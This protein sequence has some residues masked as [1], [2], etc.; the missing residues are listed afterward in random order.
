MKSGDSLS[1]SGL[2]CNVIHFIS[3]LHLF[4]CV[5]VNNVSGSVS[6]SRSKSLIGSPIHWLIWTS[7]CAYYQVIVFPVLIKGVFCLKCNYHGI[8][9][10]IILGVLTQCWSLLQTGN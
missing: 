2:D 6:L 10:L 7:F 9:L 1:L 8:L 3:V 4:I 5:Q